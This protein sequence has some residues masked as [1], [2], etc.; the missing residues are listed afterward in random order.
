MLNVRHLAVFPMRSG[1]YSQLVIRPF[2]PLIETML[3]VAFSKRDR[4]R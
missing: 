2:R 1:I 3:R 4:C